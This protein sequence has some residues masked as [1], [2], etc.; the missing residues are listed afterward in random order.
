MTKLQLLLFPKTTQE[1]EKTQKSK[2]IFTLI[3]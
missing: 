2:K 3:M 1:F